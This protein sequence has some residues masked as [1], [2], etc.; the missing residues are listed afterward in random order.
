MKKIYKILLAVFFVF[1]TGIV[2][3][4]FVSVNTAQT[5]AT[6][7]LSFKGVTNSLTLVHTEYVGT[8]EMFYVFDIMG[9]GHIIISADDR[10]EP[11]RAYVPDENYIA[12]SDNPGIAVW[13]Y[14]HEKYFIDS[15]IS[16]TQTTR[17]ISEWDFFTSPSNNQSVPMIT[18]GPLMNSIWSQSRSCENSIVVANTAASVPV[19]CVATSYGQIMNYYQHPY[20]GN[21]SSSYAEPANTNSTGVVTTASYGTLSTTHSS[22]QFDWDNMSQSTNATGTAGTFCTSGDD[23]A[24]LL[25]DLGVSFGMD[26]SPGSSGTNTGNARTDL[27]DHFGFDDDANYDLFT[28]YSTQNAWENMLQ[29]ELDASRPMVY[30][31]RRTCGTSTCGHAWVCD[32]YDIT[33]SAETFHF[34]WGWGGSQGWYA[35]PM[36]QTVGSGSTTGSTSTSNYNLSNAVVRSLFPGTDLYNDPAIQSYSA[37]TLTIRVRNDFGNGSESSDSRCNP[38]TVKFYAST[39]T[40]ITE[41]DEYLTSYFDGNGLPGNGTYQTITRTIDPSNYPSIPAGNYYIG[42]IIDAEVDVW[43]RDETNN[44][45]NLSTTTTFG[46]SG[47]TSVIACNYDSN[48]GIDDG[49]CIYLSNPTFDLTAVTWDVEADWNC[50]FTS[51]SFVGIANYYTGGTGTCLG[52]TVDWSVCGSTYS[53]YY[54]PT[55]IIYTGTY[56]N[57]VITGTMGIPGSGITGCFTLTAPS[58]TQP[59]LEITNESYLITLCFPPP[60]TTTPPVS[61]SGTTISYNVDVT[62]TGTANSSSTYLGYYLS[63]NATVYTCCA[64]Y[65]LGSD[66]VSSLSIGA[67]STET[68]T[69]DLSSSTYNSIPNGTYYIGAYADYLE[70]EA[71]YSENNNDAAFQYYFLGMSSNYYQITIQRGC[72][73]PLACN[74]DSTANIDDGNCTYLDNPT[75]NLT[76]GTWIL[77]WDFG[78]DGSNGTSTMTFNANGTA[79]FPSG[80]TVDWSMC[81][82][83]YSHS[84]SSGTLYTGTYANGIISGTLLTS[85]GTTGCFT[86]SLQTFGC[87]DPLA[88]NYNPAANTDDGSCCYDNFVTIIINTGGWG[89]E[90]DWNLTN[91]NGDTVAS[92]CCVGNY[93]S[94]TDS[95]DVQSLCLPDDCYSM[96]MYDSYG[97]GWN[98]GTYEIWTTGG[99]TNTMIATGTALHMGNVPGPAGSDTIGIGTACVVPGCTDPTACNYNPAAT[100]DDGSCNYST[101]GSATVLSCS[102]YMWNSVL[103]ITSGVFTQ[104]FTAN[105][106][107]DSIV[108]LNL[109]IGGVSG[110]TDSTACNYNPLAT[111]DDGSCYGLLGCTDPLASNYNSNATCDDGSCIYPV[112]GCT[113][114]IACNYDPTATVDDGSCTYLSS[115]AV[116]MTIG[117]WTLAWDWGCTGTSSTGTMTF[118][119]NGTAAIGIPFGAT[120]VNWS[121]CGN[122]YS[123]SY[124]SGTIYT[125]TYTANGIISGTMVSP[126]GSTGCFTL[127]R[128]PVSGCT[129]PL[130]CNYNPAATIDDGSCNYPTT[131]SFTVLSCSTYMWNSVLYITSGVFTQTFTANNGCDSIVTLNLTIGGVLGCTDP[132]AC[133]YNPLATCDDGSCYGL[134]GCTDPLASNYNSNATC[135]DGSCQYICASPVP[136]GLSVTGLTHDRA[137]VNWLAANTSLCLVEMYRVQYRELGTFVWGTK[138]ALGSGL[139]NFG[140]TTTSKMLWSLTPST[141]YEY[142]AKA[143]YCSSSAS[144]WSSISTFTTLDP[145]PNVLNFAVS[146]PLT[147]KAV[148]TWTAPSTPY[149]FVRIKLRVDSVGSAWFTAGG[150]GVMYPALTRS[151]NGLTPG[152]SYRASSRTWCNPLGG[153]HKALTWTPFIYWIQPTNSSKIESDNSIENLTIYPNPSRDIFNVS[154]VSDEVQNLDISIT[155]VVGEAIYTANLDQFVGQFTKEVSLATYPK[156]VYFLQITTDKGVITK[157]LTLQ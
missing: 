18:V 28:N 49:S 115:P 14:W 34:N 142:R 55:G 123:H 84:Y 103:Y 72:M 82:D 60:C 27:V 101:T 3:A 141:T 90:M 68:A 41:Y 113:D 139:C 52:A 94:Y 30:R 121:M 100:V 85:T 19:G 119:A 44:K 156:G 129:D 32:G 93:L 137:K 43:E 118:N 46:P 135:D 99:T 151:K 5:A 36:N 48:A 122:T 143:W 132:T 144:T 131:G 37:N 91:S 12:N 40:T 9:G 16:T 69:F 10:M 64:D 97:D 23:V 155:N 4:D 54:A 6:K 106:G 86:L 75:V 138:T 153:A 73:D 112:S 105:N 111:C 26:Y 83:D 51:P 116:D 42:W 98:G 38:Y 21:G 152:E 70:T 53:H 88:S 62:N 146:T 76:N 78:C 11:I 50:N 1:S 57:G 148:F 95:M 126:T 117:T 114:P 89:Y 109:T 136:A 39:N 22:N 81:G 125:G 17:K 96:N 108:T 80:S 2:K 25:Y 29:A 79:A 104:T 140:L 15:I 56:S 134:L 149:S 130:A 63:A 31:G 127:T 45:G 7:Y 110:C 145:C 74:Y 92:N 128:V 102:T 58:W 47:C 147:T 24:Q 65:L 77:D 59:D 61:V 35:C 8:T 157:K 67:S 71:E 107:C 87:T 154:F 20:Q 120:F 124:T 33:G 150:F 66:Y 13:K 133:N